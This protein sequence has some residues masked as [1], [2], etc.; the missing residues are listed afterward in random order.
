MAGFDIFMNPEQQETIQTD[1][2]LF[3]EIS[4]DF[5]TGEPVLKNKEF[6]ILKGTEALKVWI[7]K[8]LK[9]ERN[10][11]LIYSDSYGNDLAENIGQIYD[12]TTKDALMINEIKEC[13]L[14]NP[15]II[16]VYNFNIKTKEDG[17]HPIISFNVDTIYGTTESEVNTNIWNL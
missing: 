9:T 3:K 15:Y 11:Y 12:K 13:L 5:N 2:P 14:V 1:L 17:R 6:I 7:W 10:K 4:I 16:N 8:A